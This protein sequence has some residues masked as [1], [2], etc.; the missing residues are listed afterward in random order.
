MDTK[1]LVNRIRTPDGT[2]LEST[3]RHDFVS[4]HDANG[5]T[6]FVDGGRDYQRIGCSEGAPFPED[7]SVYVGDE[8]STIREVFTWGTYGK[9]GKQPF[10]R[11]KLSE[12]EDDHIAAI[13]TTQQHIT[14][15]VRD[16]FTRE[17]E[18]RRAVCK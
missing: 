10:R 18:E 1:I 13:L 8:H 6:Y 17:L 5:F 15:D 3:H 9:D 14:Q 4:H 7:A 11:I 12:M 2:I 16:V